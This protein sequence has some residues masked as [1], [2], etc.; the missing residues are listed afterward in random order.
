MAHY[1]DRFATHPRRSPSTAAWQ[2]L[3]SLTTRP[4]VAASGCRLIAIVWTAGSPDDGETF[5]PCRNNPCVEASSSSNVGL[6]PVY[7]GKDFP[8]SSTT[9]KN[10]DVILCDSRNSDLFHL[11]RL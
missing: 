7:R 10:H 3:K 4:P 9:V 5:E 2:P 1:I 8:C 6:A 11:H